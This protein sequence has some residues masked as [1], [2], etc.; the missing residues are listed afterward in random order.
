MN[1][2]I[3]FDLETTGATNDTNGNPFC[4]WNRLVLG[5]IKMGDNMLFFSTAPT[6]KKE[7]WGERTVVGFNIKFDLHWSR[8]YGIPL[9]RKI[10]DCQYAQFVIWRQKKPY[11]SLNDCLY[12]YGYPLK[13]DIVKTEY[14]DKE[15]DTDLVP[16]NILQEY[17]GGDLVKTEQV[18]KAQLNYLADK[19]ELMK[20]CM[21]G[22]DDI[23]TTAEMEWNGIY[24]DI[25][26]SLHEAR[27]IQQRISEI[28]VELDQLAGDY[29]INWSSND[30]V[31]AILFGG[32]IKEEYT[33]TYERILK[34]GEV[35]QKQRQSIRE[36]E[37]PSLIEPLKAWEVKKKGYYSVNAETLIKARK[38]GNKKAKKIIDLLLE[39]AKLEKLDSSYFSGLVSLYQSRGWQDSILHG[40]L[41]HCIARSGRI[42]SKEPNQQ[43]IPDQARACIITRY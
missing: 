42:A 21:V 34:S 40:Q 4:V 37:L 38:R 22:M 41:N 35:K 13:L 2:Y 12:H 25:E 36:I 23:L 17:L 31:S 26:K 9:P 6:N 5:G 43:N 18:Y 30:N 29:P 32:I 10:W 3:I 33:E 8:R 39:R 19:P 11:I 20:L 14:W 15:I 7:L 27:K 28:D 24:Y 16:P 1:D